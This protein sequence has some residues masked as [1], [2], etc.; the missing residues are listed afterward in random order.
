MG[1]K[2]EGRG[3]K[4]EGEKEEKEGRREREREG[5]EGEREKGMKLMKLIAGVALL[6]CRRRGRLNGGRLAFP[7]A[8]A[9]NPLSRGSRGSPPT[10]QGTLPPTAH[11]GVERC[12]C[13]HVVNTC[14]R[15]CRHV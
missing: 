4:R 14:L 8:E 2:K 7:E 6:G 15:V 11:Q 1:R 12:A 10:P 3:G 13:G 5:K 9:L